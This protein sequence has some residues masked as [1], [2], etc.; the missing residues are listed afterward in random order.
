[1]LAD[2]PGVTELVLDPA[3]CTGC[4]VCVHTCPEGALDVV[5]GVDLD[6]LDRGGVPIARVAVATCPDCA[7]SVPALPAS[8]H[9]PP[10]PA[11]LAGR[12]P[13]CRQAALAASG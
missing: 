7:E 8:A 12:C 9:L 13:R 3:S 11:V 1:M 10:L 2:G 6:L 5:L 4:G